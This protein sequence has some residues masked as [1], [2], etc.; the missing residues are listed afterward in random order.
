VRSDRAARSFFP[1][2]PNVSSKSR[3][4]SAGTEVS[5]WIAPSHDPAKGVDMDKKALEARAY[6][7]LKEYLVV[8]LYLW[9]FLGAFVL[10]KTIILDQDNDF[11]EHG[12]ALINALVLGKFMLLAKAFHPGRRAENAPLIYPTLLK[13]ALFA[14]ILA[15]F[16]VIEDVIVG[17]FRGKSFNESIA[18][19]GGGNWRSILVLT[20]ILFVVLIPLTAFGE[21]GRVVGEEKL[22]SHFLRPR[23]PSKSFDQQFS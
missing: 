5:I 6:H 10:Y 9:V 20:V 13:A 1:G 21:L 3:R 15:V 12:V 19:L 17:H 4:T 16:K 2:R 18:D 22:R 14:L 8:T 23:D 7:E 11:V